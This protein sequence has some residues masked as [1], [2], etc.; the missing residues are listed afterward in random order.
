MQACGEWRSADGKTY[1]PQWTRPDGRKAG[2]IWTIG[3]E[4]NVEV[5]FSSWQMEF[6]D[7]SGAK[8]RPPRRNRTFSLK[9]TDSPLYFFGGELRQGNWDK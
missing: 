1:F 8:V 6:L 5:T 3:G 7:A 2:M 4:R 9:V